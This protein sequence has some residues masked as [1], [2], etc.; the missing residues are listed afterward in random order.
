MV[1]HPFFSSLCPFPLSHLRLPTEWGLGF[2]AFT[3]ERK[4]SE[5]SPPR[6]DL[7]MD[8]GCPAGVA[9]REARWEPALGSGWDKGWVRLWRTRP[10]PKADGRSAGPATGHQEQG[11]LFSLTGKTWGRGGGG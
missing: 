2:L 1:H 8:D 11:H 10:L 9:S 4:L 7:L 3:D 6:M 5:M